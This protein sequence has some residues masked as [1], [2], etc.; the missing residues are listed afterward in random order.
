MEYETMTPEE[1]AK[2]MERI[3][4]Q[5]DPAYSHVQADAAMCIILRDLGYGEGI[6]Y[7]ENMRKWYE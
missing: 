5:R 4:S 3:A 1:F 6:T 7:F 2:A